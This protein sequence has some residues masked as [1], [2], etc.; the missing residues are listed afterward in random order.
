MSSWYQKLFDTYA[1]PFNGAGLDS[2]NK[3]YLKQR[4]D[5]KQGHAW[6]HEKR[7]FMQ[8]YSNAREG[9]KVIGADINNKSSRWNLSSMYKTG[10]F[11]EEEGGQIAAAPAIQSI[12]ITTTGTAGSMRKAEVKFKVYSYIQLKAAQKAFFVPGMSAVV[13]WGWNIK[14]DGT[15]VN[16]N[17]D[18]WKNGKSLLGV[19][20]AIHSWQKANDGCVD[21]LGGLI[22]DFGWSKTQGAG[23]DSKGFDCNITLESPSKTY[24]AGTC[25][26]PSNLACGCPNSSEDSSK[27][28]RGGWVKQCLKDQAESEMGQKSMVGKVWKVGGKMLGVSVKFDQDYQSDPEKD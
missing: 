19:T 12:T 11:I 28:A 20:R 3:K 26:A 6:K 24:M 27:K 17:I 14:Q 4:A 18:I 15:P 21:G 10:T 9:G 7:T 5:A 22:S 16:P 2:E 13:L 1:N 23:A 25:Q 8:L